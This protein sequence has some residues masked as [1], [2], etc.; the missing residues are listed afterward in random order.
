[1]QILQGGTSWNSILDTTLD[2]SSHYLRNFKLT[3][4][5]SLLARNFKCYV[6]VSIMN[7]NTRYIGPLHDYIS[8][9]NIC[10]GVVKTFFPSCCSIPKLQFVTVQKIWKMENFPSPDSWHVAPSYWSSWLAGWGKIPFFPLL[11]FPLSPPP[12]PERL[13][14]LPFSSP[15]AQ[16]AWPPGPWL[17]RAT[18]PSLLGW[19]ARLGRTPYPRVF[20]F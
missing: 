12:R 20:Y 17:A 5:A 2:G 6:M 16:P 19:L 8:W 13:L 15:T 4:D 1:M 18:P 11:P 3:T 9:K 10:G 14:C 7:D